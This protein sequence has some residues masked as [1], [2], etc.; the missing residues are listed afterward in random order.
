MAPQAWVQASV[1]APPCGA[2]R[3]AAEEQRQEAVGRQVQRAAR[4]LVE[5]AAPRTACTSGSPKRR[6]AVDVLRTPMVLHAGLVV[7]R[8]GLPAPT[9]NTEAQGERPEREWEAQS[10]T[11]AEA[12]HAQKTGGNLVALLVGDA[13]LCL[14]ASALRSPLK[15]GRT[16]EREAPPVILGIWTTVKEK[17][18]RW[19]ILS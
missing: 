13:R 2:E 17:G 11:P 15:K 5:M 6:D 12:A 1:W 8:T 14:W 4:A 16:I 19:V 7:V 18:K 10:T 3:M 9:R